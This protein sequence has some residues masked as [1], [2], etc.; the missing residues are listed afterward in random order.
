MRDVPDE[1]VDAVKAV[2]FKRKIVDAFSVTEALAAVAPLIVAQ[3]RER[4][5]QVLA[6]LVLTYPPQSI[7]WDALIE[8]AAAIRA[9][10]P[11]PTP[12][13]PPARST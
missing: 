2:L 9:P 4:C 3:E 12:P 11:P 7:A 6:D 1:W 13:T 10:S 5:E 8:A